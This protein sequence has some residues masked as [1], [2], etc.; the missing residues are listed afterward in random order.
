[1]QRA[2]RAPRATP[3]TNRTVIARRP[4]V[5]KKDK[6]NWLRRHHNAE[7]R[8][9]LGLLDPS[10]KLAT[11]WPSPVPVATSAQT[12]K[13][14]LT[15]TANATGNLCVYLCPLWTNSSSPFGLYSANSA[16][17]NSTATANAWG[18]TGN[19]PPLVSAVSTNANTFG[20][21]RIVS[22]EIRL[23]DANP[24]TSSS[25]TVVAGAVPFSQIFQFYQT[26]Y[27]AAL[28]NSFG[29]DTVK[30]SYGSTQVLLRNATTG[31]R[32][33]AIPLSEGAALMHNAYNNAT[34][35]ALSSSV[36]WCVPV[37]FL[38]NGMASGTY[39]LTYHVNV[40]CIPAAGYTDFL[41]TEIAPGGTPAAALSHIS[42]VST[43][44][45]HGTARSGFLGSLAD[46]AE[47]SFVD[48]LQALKGKVIGSALDALG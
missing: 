35:N 45:I 40:E 18:Y 13:G 9:A 1:V 11:R 15:V 33:V 38:T 30:D 12:F 23:L 47:E 5:P 32:S 44:T 27:P 46:A 2:P 3:S 19:T 16:A 48:I 8:F 10:A 14:S 41:P 6:D 28:V 17:V 36:D 21:M 26:G 7:I 34:S 43:S 37:L 31:V 42:R 22:G 20:A 25:G 39:T 24:I 29:Y 4:R